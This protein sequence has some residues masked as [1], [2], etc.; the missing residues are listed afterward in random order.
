MFSSSKLRHTVYVT[1]VLALTASMNYGQKEEAKS[2]T[3]VF[4]AIGMMFAHGSGLARME[5]TDA[6]IE[7]IPDQHSQTRMSTPSVLYY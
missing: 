5:F 3:E 7:S 2:D 4:E 1:I 6:E